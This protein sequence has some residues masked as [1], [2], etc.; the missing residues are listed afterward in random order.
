MSERKIYMHWSNDGRDR[1]GKAKGFPWHGR[2]WLHFWDHCLRFEWVLWSLSFAFGITF[3]ENEIHLRFAFPPFSFFLSLEVR[4]LFWFKH[5]R[6]TDVRIFDWAIWW[7]FWNDDNEW[8][9]KDRWKFWMHGNF[10]PIDFFLGQPKF[11]EEVLSEHE[12]V[13]PMPEG[14]YQANVTLLES[15][16]KRPRWLFTKRLLR[17]NIKPKKPIPFPGKGENSWDCGEDGM[18]ALHTTAKTVEEAIAKTVESALGTRR[19]RGDLMMKY[20]SPNDE[21]PTPP[22]KAA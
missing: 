6:V 18:H 2:A 5:R 12:V 8:H 9:S 14:A 1:K 22:L 20:P 4:K 13:I 19:R 7:N 16:W 17:A 21:P 3:E 10:H 11:H 15:S